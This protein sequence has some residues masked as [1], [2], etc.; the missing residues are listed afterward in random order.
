MLVGLDLLWRI[1]SIPKALAGDV[2]DAAWALC[3][4]LTKHSLGENE[5]SEDFPLPWVEQPLELS[6]PLAHMLK[7][8][9]VAL[10]PYDR[11][12]LTKDLPFVKDIQASVNNY[13]KDAG[14]QIEK[15]H[16]AW[17]TSALHI[18]RS[19][20]MLDLS[21]SSPESP[22]CDLSRSELLE[23]IFTCAIDFSNRVNEYRKSKSMPPGTRKPS[24]L[25]T[26]FAPQ[27]K[28]YG[29]TT[30]NIISGQGV[31]LFPFWA[32]SSPY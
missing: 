17:E 30:P 1:N 18:A 20:A 2:K 9:S 14:A 27:G 10:D 3:N 15:V 16:R 25:S 28:W 13:R 7:Y 5:D 11:S 22:P 4:A 24:S 23:H 32:I 21:M 31:I 12:K 6:P 29:V 19:T 8:L 26:P